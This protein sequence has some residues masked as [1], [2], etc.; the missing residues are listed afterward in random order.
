MGIVSW[1][2]KYVAVSGATPNCE[3]LQI[4]P[5]APLAGL[6]RRVHHTSIRRDERLYEAHSS[7]APPSSHSRCSPSSMASSC[8]PVVPHTRKEVPTRKQLFIRV[9]PGAASRL[10]GRQTT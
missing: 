1:L 9:A 4:A 5:E 8:W 3:V 10:S 2:K 6:R 7:S